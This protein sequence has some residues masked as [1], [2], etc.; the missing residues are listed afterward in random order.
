MPAR[1]L[2]CVAAVFALVAV[3]SCDGQES[4]FPS[5]PTS[6]T[7]ERDAPQLS[8]SLTQLRIYEGTRKIN[9]QIVN[10]DDSTVTVTSVQLRASGSVTLPPTPKN[11]VYEPGRTIDLSTRFGNPY[12]DPGAGLHPVFRLGLADGT[13]VDLPVNASGIATLRRLQ[14]REC[15]LERIST[16]ASIDL[17]DR[18]TRVVVGSNEY[19]RGTLVL[20]RPADAAALGTSRDILRV[21]ELVGSVL[22]RLLPYRSSVPAV[23]EPGQR[24][25]SIPILIGTY[26]CDEHARSQA[27]QAFV[28]SAFLLESRQRQPGDVAQRFIIE[29]DR[30]LETR[31]LVLIE[32]VCG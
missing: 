3:C 24:R 32:D 1:R 19:L 5:E 15:N 29:P 18:F 9:A 27:L 30:Q 6:P 28:W 11:T 25:L 14:D 31:T 13:V 22:V 17:G 20:E 12:C 26:R 2:W 16:I 21:D 23:L 8:A 7:A 4:R 10:S